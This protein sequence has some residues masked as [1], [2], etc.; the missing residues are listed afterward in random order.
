M[1]VEL[2]LVYEG[3]LRVQTYK[4]NLVCFEKIVVEGKAGLSHFSPVGGSA[5]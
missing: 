4:P 5:S 3:E 2:K 1:Q